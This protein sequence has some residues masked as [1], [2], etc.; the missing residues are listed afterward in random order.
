MQDLGLQEAILQN[1]ADIDYP[2]TFS[3]NT[4]ATPID[5]VWASPALDILQSGY[6]AYGV[7]DHRGAWIDVDSTTL[8]GG[9]ALFPHTVT[10]RRLQLKSPSTVQ[11]YIQKYQQLVDKH[12]L[13][14]RIFRL[15]NT[16]QED[17]PLTM[18][19]IHEIEAIDT[20][21]T[22]LMLQ[23]EKHCRKLRMGAIPFSPQVVQP[24]REKEYWRL[25]RRRM[26]GKQVSSRLLSRRRKMAGI[27]EPT[28]H[29]TLEE[30]IRRQA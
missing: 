24:A 16:I 29:L 12:N 11:R 14:A 30:V 19:Q 3:R 1:N 17:I 21:R 9:G 15:E 26:E 10:A 4:T 22:K 2:A 5:G 28:N 6:T 20:L 18:E 23:A 7:W 13:A 25:V 8:F 27:T